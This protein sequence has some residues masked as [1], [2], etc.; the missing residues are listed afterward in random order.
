MTCKK[1]TRNHL[2]LTSLLTLFLS[3]WAVLAAP[4]MATAA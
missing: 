2:A 1:Y 4:G 3:C